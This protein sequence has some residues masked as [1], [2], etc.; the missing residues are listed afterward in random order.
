MSSSASSSACP[1][2]QHPCQAWRNPFSSYPF[3]ESHMDSIKS[4]SNHLTPFRRGNRTCCRPCIIISLGH[5]KKIFSM[6]AS[7]SFKVLASLFRC[8]GFWHCQPWI[9]RWLLGRSDPEHSIFSRYCENVF[10]KSGSA[11]DH[12]SS[13]PSTPSS[14]DRMV[15]EMM[16]VSPGAGGIQITRST[17]DSHWFCLWRVPYGFDLQAHPRHLCAASS[18][19]KEQSC[20]V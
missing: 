2:G 10:V 19:L 20:Y 5:P 14:V 3:K 13:A 17:N 6:F 18:V 9:S 12:S 4:K 16:G 7:Y 8:W 15:E 11:N 1:A